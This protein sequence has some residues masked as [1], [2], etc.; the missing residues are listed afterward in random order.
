MC[1]DE[2]LLAL[3]DP[4]QIVGLSPYAADRSMSF[5]AAKAANYRH[6]AAE[7]ETVVD[8]HP[9]LVLAGSFTNPRR[10]RC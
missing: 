9:D 2:L 3:A 10:W 8:L 4:D 6:D 1:A 7:A 5:M